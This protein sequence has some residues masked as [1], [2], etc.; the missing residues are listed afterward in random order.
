MYGAYIAHLF[1]LT[2]DRSIKV[3]DREHCR[4]YLGKWKQPKI[5][6]GCA[7]DVEALKPVTLL[8]LSLHSDGADIVLSMV[9]TMKA[10]KSLKKLLQLEWPM[11]QLVKKGC[12]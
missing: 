12:K 9:N 11:V 10:V 4:G 1:V 3:E 7:M 6:I 2:E 8:S 5:L